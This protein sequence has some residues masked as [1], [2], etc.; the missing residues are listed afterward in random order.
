MRSFFE[1]VPLL[2]G[3]AWVKDAIELFDPAWKLEIVSNLSGNV[4]LW[5]TCLLLI[6]Q[7]YWFKKRFFLIVLAFIRLSILSKIDESVKA[8]RI[9]T[10]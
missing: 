1:S 7:F 8:A 10:V 5:N 9:K 3:E 6:R 4:W 2:D